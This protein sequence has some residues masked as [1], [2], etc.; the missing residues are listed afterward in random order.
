MTNNDKKE[1]SEQ[2]DYATSLQ[3][4][5]IKELYNEL[6]YPKSRR[7]D[8]KDLSLLSKAD[9]GNHIEALIKLK[10]ATNGNG[11]GSP[12]GF[13]KIGYSMIYKLVWRDWDKLS[14]N[15]FFKDVSFSEAVLMEYEKYKG[16]LEFAE[17]SVNG[18]GQK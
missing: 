8:D 14:S 11:K 4:N 10:R 9:A 7:F 6:T 3:T 15:A 13:D 1:S 17:K 2:I 5:T 12:K 16:A 18:S